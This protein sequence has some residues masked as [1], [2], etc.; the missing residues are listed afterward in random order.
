MPAPCRL[1]PRWSDPARAWRH[2]P[3]V[4]DLGAQPIGV[5][6]GRDRCS[7]GCRETNSTHGAVTGETV[8]PRLSIHLQDYR[9]AGLAIC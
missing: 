1:R 6:L 9:A 3:I 5:R 2:R 7:P 4:R 8:S